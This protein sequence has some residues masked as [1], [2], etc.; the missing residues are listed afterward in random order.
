MRRIGI[1]LA[2]GFFLSATPALS[3]RS[4]RITWQASSDAA[5]NP[6][7]TYNVYRASSCAGQ[8][9]KV[10]ASPVSF[11]SYVDATVGVGAA[12]C[13]RVT[14]V[15]NGLESAPSNQVIAAIPPPPNRQASCEH[16]GP[17]VGWIRCIGTH[18]KSPAP[19]QPAP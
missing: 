4:V 5:A 12:Y 18:P 9:S 7:L 6:S 16:H 17:L 15:L 14:A 13:Y 2:L 3:Q 10:N 1:A 8:F 11:T 19:K